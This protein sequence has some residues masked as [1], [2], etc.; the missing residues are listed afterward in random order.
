MSGRRPC[1]CLTARFYLL[2]NPQFKVRRGYVIGTHAIV[3]FA[4]AP[5]FLGGKFERWFF[6]DNNAHHTLLGGARVKT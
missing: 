5:E 4:V 6:S 3:S 1:C 2:T